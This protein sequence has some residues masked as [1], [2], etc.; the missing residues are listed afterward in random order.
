MIWIIVIFV[1]IFLFLFKGTIMKNGD[2]CSE[3]LRCS[4]NVQLEAIINSYG[5]MTDLQSAL[6]IVSTNH[7]LSIIAWETCGDPNAKT[8]EK[9]VQEYSWGLMQI[10]LS[11]AKK[12]QPN[13]T[14]EALLDPFINI[15]IGK[16][17]VEG[18]MNQFNIFDLQTI[19]AHYN[20]GTN[21]PRISYDRGNCVQ[22]LSN[23]IGNI[24]DNIS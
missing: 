21:P 13:I 22:E 3:G 20:G 17:V 12:I 24:R 2:Y 18:D 11:T 15:G 1:L 4:S 14:G 5:W 10:L 9:N 8:W 6:S 23:R 16:K 19:Y 7:L